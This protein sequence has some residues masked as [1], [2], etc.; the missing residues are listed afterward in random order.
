VAYESGR[1]RGGAAGFRDIY[2]PWPRA[3]SELP[4]LRQVAHEVIPALRGRTV[5]AEGPAAQSHRRGD[6]T[7]VGEAAVARAYAA[8]RDGTPRRLLDFLIDHPT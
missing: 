4:V 2:L 6:L 3:E 5:P 1:L 8:V 7:T